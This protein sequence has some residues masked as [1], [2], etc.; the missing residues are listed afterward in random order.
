[1]TYNVEP[2]CFKFLNTEAGKCSNL[3]GCKKFENFCFPVTDLAKNKQ[4]MPNLEFFWQQF[5]IKT[6]KKEADKNQNKYWEPADKKLRK[7]TQFSAEISQFSADSFI[8]Y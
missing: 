6:N 7:A 4:K 3:I 1:M 8:Y 5:K 2:L